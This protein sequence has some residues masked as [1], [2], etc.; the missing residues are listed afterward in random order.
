MATNVTFNGT[1]YS[2]PAEGDS[3]W[4]TALSNYFIAIGTGCLQKTGGTFTLTAETDF[5]ASFGLK[6]LYLKSRATNPASAGIIRLGNNENIS[7]RNAANNANLSLAVDTSDNLNFNGTS[8]SVGGTPVQTEITVSDTD[9]INLTLASNDIS[10]IVVEGSLGNA[11]I[12]AD[13]AIAYSKLD[14]GDSVINADIATGAAIAL[15]K[16]AVVTA[17]RALVSDGD[18]LI[19]ASSVTATE[20]GLLSGRTGTLAT[21]AETQT[22]TNKTIVVANNTVTTAASGNLAATE[23]NTALAELQTDIDTRALDS[24]LTDHISDA[25]GAHAASA[26]SFSATGSIAATDIQAAIAEVSGDIDGHISDASGAHAASAISA[27]ATSPLTETDVQGQLDEIAGLLGG[28]NL[29][30]TSKTAN[31]TV[32]TSDAIILCDS[33]GGAF[34]LTLPAASG[35]TGK[36][37]QIKKTDSSF[38]A[39]TI[40]GDGSETIDG[41]TTTTV[42]TEGETLRI[43]CDGSNWQILERRIPGE[44]KAYTPTLTTNT[45]TMTNFTVVAKSRRVGD[46]LELT[47]SITFS[48]AAGTWSQPRIPLPS[49]LSVDTAK[50]STTSLGSSKG[51]AS[52]LDVGT[53]VYQGRTEYNPSIS[54]VIMRSSQVNT[55]TAANLDPV[56]D[57]DVSNTVPFSWASGDVINFD[58][59][60]IP[61]TGWT[62]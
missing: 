30:V 61:I 17:S 24:A 42:N 55:S 54:S 32:T 59:S 49:G 31:Y 6:A 37:F 57:E 48:G 29:A 15:S 9:T 10:G 12:A 43:V 50:L 40:D 4:G 20:L 16:L 27:T 35:N 60:G 19:S 47:G 52:F 34:T 5:G 14:L 22:L 2:V 21:L 38:L 23:L 8:I 33:S 28:G 11:H 25:S 7:W 36:V 45:G 58:I 46:C 44:W 13:A 18:G 1:V 26:I 62:G 53:R 41:A 39:V 51:T 3:N 56:F